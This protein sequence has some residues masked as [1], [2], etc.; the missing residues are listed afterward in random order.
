[1]EPG[2]LRHRV[3]IEVKSDERDSYGQP[4]SWKTMGVVSADIRSVTGRDFIS[5]NAERSNVT[6]KIFMRYREDVRATTTRLVEVTSSGNGRVYSV[7][8]P[9]PTRDRRNMEVLCTED[10]TRVY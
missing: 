7:T 3:R 9:L 5:G 6:T 4:V 8:A 10:F 2:R 1:M